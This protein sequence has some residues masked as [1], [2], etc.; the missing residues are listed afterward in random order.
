MNKEGTAVRNLV[1]SPFLTKE[2]G[3]TFLNLSSIQPY[4]S[5]LLPV[6]AHTC[7]AV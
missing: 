6:K 5:P 4:I 7:P 1:S 3:K 2:I